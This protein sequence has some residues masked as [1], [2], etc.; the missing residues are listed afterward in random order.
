MSLSDTL[1]M[2][3]GGGRGT[4]LYPLTKERCKPAVPLGGK[5]RLIDVPISNCINSGLRQIY[6]VSQ[7]NSASLNHH[8]AQAYRM[9][10][11]TNSF[12]SVLAATQ[13]DFWREDWFQGT[14]DAVRKCVS[15]AH[16][17]EYKRVVILSGDQLYKMDYR[18]ML[19]THEA[20][21]AD[22]TIG[23]LPVERDKV[24]AF[25]IM[26]IDGEDSIVDFVEKPKD[27]EVVERYRVSEEFAAKTGIAYTDKRW[28]ASMGIYVFDSR[29]LLEILKDESQIDFGRDVIPSA[30]SRYKTC[31]HLFDGYW[32]DIG[33]IKSFFEAN[34][35]L[36]ARWPE[37]DFYGDEASKIFTNQRY[38]NA[39][40]LMGAHVTESMISDGCFIDEGTAIIKSVIGLRSSIGAGSHIEEAVIFGADYYKRPE[41]ESARPPLGIGPNTLIKRAILDKNVTIGAG[42]KIVNRHNTEHEDGEFY[43]IRNGVVVIP[44][45]AVVPPGAVI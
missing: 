31:A 36:G 4:R 35:M 19:E 16:L 45:G 22:I 24:D 6:I 42:A 14:A 43:H 27:A 17:P 18:K 32:E 7:F 10:S 40:R 15:L 3:L 25:G 28:L 26:R 12:V 8:V 38:L 13:T 9:D 5:Y 1:A 39:S 41:M 29:V 11:F 20:H 30:L 21:D 2:I 33:T 23:V 37:F 34:I 44:K